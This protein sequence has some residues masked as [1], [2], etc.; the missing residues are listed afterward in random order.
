MDGLTATLDEAGVVDTDKLAG[1]P[2]ETGV[3]VDGLT[4]TLDEAGV[5][6]MD[7]LTGALDETGVDVDG[8][9][10]TLDEAG[11]DMDRLIITSDV[12]T[13]L[14]VKTGIEL[15]RAVSLL[16]LTAVTEDDVVTVL[17][18]GDA[19][20]VLLVGIKLG[21]ELSAT[22]GVS[23]TALVG[24]KDDEKTVVLTVEVPSPNLEELLDVLEVTVGEGVISTPELGEDSEVLG[25]VLF[26]LVD[27]ACVTGVT[28]I[29][30]LRVSVWV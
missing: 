1:T 13:E 23:I 6:D 22:E 17:M 11:V 19:G 7:K 26:A 2:N 16:L 25:V 27:R 24:S 8:I 18:L 10:T 30:E 21:L 5:V 3:D 29:T 28:E 12:N 15:G 9:I 20:P 4:T 14:L